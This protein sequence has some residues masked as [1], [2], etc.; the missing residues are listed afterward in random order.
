MPEE[1]IIRVQV[2]DK[3]KVPIATPIGIV[4]ETVNGNIKNKFRIDIPITGYAS[5]ASVQLMDEEGVNIL[6]VY[7]TRFTV[8]LGDMIVIP[9]GD[10]AIDFPTFPTPVISGALRQVSEQ[11]QRA[12]H[13]ATFLTN[14]DRVVASS[15]TFTYAA[16]PAQKK[17]KPR[18]D[19]IIQPI[20][21]RFDL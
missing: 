2:I 9:A 21:R 14:G 16:D 15:R 18:T 19:K 10:L 5:P 6:W 17:E 11:M 12:R 4:M 7:R 3:N 1:R 13:R 8:G 20:K